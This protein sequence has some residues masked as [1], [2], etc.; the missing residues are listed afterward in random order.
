MNKIINLILT[1]ISLLIASNCKQNYNI[2]TVSINKIDTSGIH[3]TY[4]H[5][6]EKFKATLPLDVTTE[7]VYSTDSLRIKIDKNNPSRFEFVSIVKRKW[8]KEEI[9]ITKKN[10]GKPVKAFNMIDEKPLFNGAKNEFE[11]DSIL[12]EYFRL[13]S[14]N[15][16]SL[17]LVGVYILING[18]GKASLEEAMT[19]DEAEIKHIKRLIDDLPSFTAPVHKGDTVTVSYLIEVPVFR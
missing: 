2:E 4:D 11:N 9:F 17:K 6:G 5:L 16:G 10:N 18:T 1:I 15:N 19:K 7:N 3:F 8:H 12:Y 13:N 14:K